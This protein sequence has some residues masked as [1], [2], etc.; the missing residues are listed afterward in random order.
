MDINVD[1]NAIISELLE[2][3]KN[4][5]LENIVLKKVVQQLQTAEEEEESTEE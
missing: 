5:T 4:L 3:N 1:P 2:L